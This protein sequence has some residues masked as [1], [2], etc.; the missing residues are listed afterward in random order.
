M[1]VWTRLQRLVA[2]PVFED[3]E[4]KTRIA[5]LLNLVLLIVMAMVILYSVPALVKTPELGRVLN[6][7][8]FLGLVVFMLVLLRSGHVRLAGFSLSFTLWAMITFGTYNIGGFHG[9]VMSSYFGVILIAGLLLGTWAGIAF[10]AL[11]IAATGWMYYADS[12]GFMPPPPNYILSYGDFALW[13]EFSV[14]VVGMVGLLTLV[15]NSLHNALER[16]RRNEKELAAKVIETQQLA[17]Q[18]IE[19]NEF[20][21]SLIGRV[22][23]ELRTP[24]GVVLGMA[25]MLHYDAVG[26]LSPK[27]KEITQKIIDNSEYLGSVFAELLDQSEVESGRLRLREVGFAPQDL[28]KQVHSSFLPLAE[29]KGLALQLETATDMPAALLGDPRRIGQILSNLVGNAIKFTQTGA[30]RVCVYKVDDEHWALQVNDTG[31][32]I[33]KEVQAFIFDPFRQADETIG[34]GQGG[35]GL[36]L[37]IVKQLVAAMNGA[38][39]VES[40]VGRGSTF[41]VLLPLRL[42]ISG[43]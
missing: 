33:P 14:V 12:L 5:G 40:E 36:G 1:T 11:S 17:Q 39:A 22:S 16:A 19:A 24:L 27:Q 8:V 29:R 43:N 7:I 37:S 6:E 41:T 9:S 34:Q 4:E 38:V 13:I 42:A 3:D 30:V 10:G 28:L 18:A 31:I 2:P 32:G 25:E 21:S 20:K 23:H 15:M 35:V 26:P